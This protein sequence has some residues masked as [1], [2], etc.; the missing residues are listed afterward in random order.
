MPLLRCLAAL[1][2]KE[3]ETA[4]TKVLELAAADEV[5]VVVASALALKLGD[6]SNTAMKGVE[7][8][9]AIKFFNAAFPLQPAPKSS[10][11]SKAAG[12]RFS[13]RTGCSLAHF[14]SRSPRRVRC[15]LCCGFCC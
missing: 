5:V 15:C 14:P 13:R 7:I 10:H 6:E 11:S 2:A 1:V 4:T 12:V 9:L 3:A 8:A